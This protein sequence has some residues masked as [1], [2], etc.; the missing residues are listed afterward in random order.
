MFP[1]KVRWGRA[2]SSEPL[3]LRIFGRQSVRRLH[4]MPDLPPFS[5]IRPGFNVQKRGC[6]KARRPEV[7]QMNP[8]APSVAVMA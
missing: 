7:S 6:R 2:R 5:F 4:A 8:A 3:A 1:P